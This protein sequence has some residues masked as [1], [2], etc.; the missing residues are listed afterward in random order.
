MGPADSFRAGFAG[1][2]TP[3]VLAAQ[4]PAAQRQSADRSIED[5]L[6]ALDDLA[7]VPLAEQ[8]PLFDAVHSALTEALATID[9]V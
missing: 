3:G 4:A 9:R 5:S 2:P 7:T 8:V 6:A 1:A